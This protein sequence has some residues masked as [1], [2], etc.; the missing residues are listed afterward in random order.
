M[1]DPKAGGPVAE[2]RKRYRE[3]GGGRS[4]GCEAVADRVEGARIPGFS[5]LALPMPRSA[6]DPW[7]IS[8][9]SSTRLNRPSGARS[10]KA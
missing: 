5:Y 2:P 4:C 1:P 6:S 7:S 8:V 10:P 3:A 9:T